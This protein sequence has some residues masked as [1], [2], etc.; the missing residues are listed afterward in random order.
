[1]RINFPFL[2]NPTSLIIAHPQTLIDPS[3]MPTPQQEEDAATPLVADSS[4]VA[5]SCCCGASVES[6]SI[7]GMGVRW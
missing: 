6:G 5:P 1:M 2:S 4:S 3:A 7:R